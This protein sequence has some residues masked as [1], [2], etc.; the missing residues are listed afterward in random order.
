[1]LASEGLHSL[2]LKCSTCSIEYDRAFGHAQHWQPEYD[3]IGTQHKPLSEWPY[4]EHECRRELLRNRQNTKK[5]YAAVNR[6]FEIYRSLL[7]ERVKI[8]Y[9]KLLCTH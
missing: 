4:V 5:P 8:R 9:Y 6:V 1:M 7:T 3:G 2:F